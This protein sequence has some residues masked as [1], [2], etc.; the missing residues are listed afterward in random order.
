[1]TPMRV[2]GTARG[3]R[4]RRGAV[5]LEVL[6]SLVLLSL[7]GLVMVQ[8]LA[9]AYHSMQAAH[10]AER[11]FLQAIALMDAA[12]L[13]STPDLNRRLGERRQG[14]WI[15]KIDRPSAGLYQ[16]TVRRAG[17]SEALLKTSLRRSVD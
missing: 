4:C 11:E 5:V 7:F 13:W 8:T 9:D 16:F 1:M 3:S 17:S 10:A 15:M 2:P 12:L 6:L 14:P